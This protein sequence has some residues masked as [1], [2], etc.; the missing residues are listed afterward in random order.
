MQNIFT[1]LV[2]FGNKCLFRSSLNHLN[3]KKRIT[4]PLSLLSP[5]RAAP[6]LS[7]FPQNGDVPGFNHLCRPLLGTLQQF[8]TFLELG[9][10]ELD[11]VLQMWPHQDRAELSSSSEVVIEHAWEGTE[12][13]SPS[14]ADGFPS[15]IVFHHPIT[16]YHSLPAGGLQPAETPVLPQH[17]CVL[18]LLLSGKPCLI[19]QRPGGVGTWAEGLHAQCALCPHRNTGNTPLGHSSPL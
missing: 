14:W 10:P 13:S 18:D 6:G 15:P 4:S 19:P 7:A 1:Q 8:P 12:L 3:K 5:G 9:T 11:A 16:Y 2:C 17:R